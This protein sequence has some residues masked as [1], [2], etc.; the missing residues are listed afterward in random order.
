[1]NGN[2]F[3]K[4]NR[5]EEPGVET[6]SFFADPSTYIGGVGGAMR[7]L[8]TRGAGKVLQ[9]GAIVGA[10]KA[11]SLA[12]DLLAADKI[13]SLSRAAKGIQ[14]KETYPQ[15]VKGL[16]ELMERAGWTFKF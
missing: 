2:P 4:W 11:P 7:K 8:A 10:G 15:L 14:M 16:N 5:P 1:M 13:A 3:L 9:H 6:P 12:P